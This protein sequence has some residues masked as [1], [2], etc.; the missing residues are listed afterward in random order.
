MRLFDSPD[1]YRLAFQQGEAHGKLAAQLE[2]LT[3]EL[4]ELRKAIPAGEGM[5]GLDPAITVVLQGLSH[6]DPALYR[7]LEAQARELVT[8]GADP[9]QVIA[10]LKRGSNRAPKSSDG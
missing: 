3:K 4:S 7:F 5:L 6:G 10:Q 2:A 9:K 1:L 8:A